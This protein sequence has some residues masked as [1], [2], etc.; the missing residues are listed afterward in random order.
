[1]YA[2]VPARPPPCVGEPC[3]GLEL[4]SGAVLQEAL[5]PT[6]IC[7]RQ[8]VMLCVAGQPALLTLHQVKRVPY[9]EPSS[10]A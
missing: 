9:L 8:Q 10:A 2:S 4:T 5:L 1:V 3:R 7:V 6:A